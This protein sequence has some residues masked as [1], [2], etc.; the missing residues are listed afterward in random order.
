MVKRIVVLL[1]FATLG[2]VGANGAQAQVITNDTQ[3]LG[4]AGFVPCANGGAGEIL[5]GTVEVHNLS[6]STANG[7]NEDSLF[8]F[9][10]YGSMVGAS[11]GDTYRVAG[12]AHGTSHESAQND[13]YNLTYVNTFQLVGPGPD[14]NLLVHE[15]AH[16]TVIAD[17]VVVQH[18][19]LTIDCR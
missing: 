12:V 4:F 9:Q 6:T 19:D 3:Q 1:A 14:N 15:T 10:V 13:D 8:Q 11:T 17:E 5:T 7:N 2:I 18:D 16:L